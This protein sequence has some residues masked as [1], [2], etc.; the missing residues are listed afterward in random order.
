MPTPSS[1][2]ALSPEVSRAQRVAVLG[3]PLIALVILTAGY[4]MILRPKFAELRD[5]RART[6]IASEIPALEQRITRLDSSSEKLAT[7]RALLERVDF[8]LPGE[9]D[10]PGL[11]ATID[12]AAQRAGV[13]ASS[14]N[15]VRGAL[16]DTRRALRG[17]TAL[18][19]EVTLYGVTYDQLK[20][21]LHVLVSSERL[22]DILSVRFSPGSFSGSVRVRAYALPP[23]SEMGI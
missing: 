2:S 15:V 8:A 11:F 17:V 22:I 19:T 9:E 5:L 12:A 6:H 23:R 7:H 20:A 3:M 21:F 14:V 16:P 10:I 13:I 4:V 1:P 18:T